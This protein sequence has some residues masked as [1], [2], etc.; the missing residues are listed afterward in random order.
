MKYPSTI[1]SVKAAIRGISYTFIHEKNF[2]IEVMFAIFVVVFL[3]ITD[4]EA[5]RWIISIVMIIVILVSELA[6]TA[7]ERIV[8]MLKP[9]KHPYAK[10]V[11]DIA[12][13][14]VLVSVIGVGVAGIA[15]LGPLICR[16]FTI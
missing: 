6:N 4:A 2:K 1:K 13:G 16:I 10:V 5:W 12:A 8:D 3:T 14:M 15:V 9:Q 7:L 11:K